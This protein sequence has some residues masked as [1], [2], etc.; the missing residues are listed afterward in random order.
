MFESNGSIQ[1]ENI[2]ITTLNGSIPLQK[3]T[4]TPPNDLKSY[5]TRESLQKTTLHHAFY[6]QINKQMK[7]ITLNIFH[8]TPHFISTSQ[9]TDSSDVLHSSNVSMVFDAC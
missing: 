5:I 7:Y 3:V 4:T 9:T 8:G 6:G 1:I 2:I